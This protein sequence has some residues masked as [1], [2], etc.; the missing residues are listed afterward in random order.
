MEV[1]NKTWLG[2]NVY[3]TTNPLEIYNRIN[4]ILMFVIRNGSILQNYVYVCFLDVQT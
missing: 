2:E 4:A 1:S 3:F